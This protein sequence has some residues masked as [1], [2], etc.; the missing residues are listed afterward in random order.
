MEKTKKKVEKNTIKKRPEKMPVINPDRKA[1]KKPEKAPRK[2]KLK[3][4]EAEEIRIP[5]KPI[6][7]NSVEESVKAPEVVPEAAIEPIQAVPEEEAKK[8]KKRGTT[9]LK[10]CFVSQ[11]AMNGRLI[12]TFPSI[13]DAVMA[14]EISE[15]TIL[16]YINGKRYQTGGYMWGYE[17]DG[18]R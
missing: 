14:M 11:Y 13:K 15:Q 9:G 4:V 7:K 10:T 5:I 1:D 8:K 3:L 18:L 16:D 2:S 6:A 17:K 12:R